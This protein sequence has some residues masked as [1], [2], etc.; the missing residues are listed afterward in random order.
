[1]NSRCSWGALCPPSR[2]WA[3]PGGAGSF[4]PSGVF[5]LFLAQ[6]L[7]AEKSCGAALLG[8]IA[9][10]AASQDDLVS[11]DKLPSPVT[12]GYCQ[13]R[14]RLPLEKVAA[15]QKL[16]LERIRS[17][18]PAEPTWCGR[19]VRVVDGSSVSM[20]DTPS[21]QERYPQP[22]GQAKG[23]G[24]PVIRIVA[25]FSLGTG[26]LLELAKDALATS[27][28]AL[29]RSLWPHLNPG[30][31]LLADCG[32]CS[33]ADFYLLSQRGVDC[34]MRNHQRRSKGVVELERLGNNDR[35]VD[36]IKT[37]VR[38]KALTKK[39]WKT[40]PKTLRVR[41]ITV[42]VD[43]PGFRSRRIVVVT[44]LLDPKQ[45]PT[46]AFAELYRARWQA[47]LYL[48]NIKTALGMDILRCKEPDMVQKELA[49]HVIAYNLIRAIMV[50][51]ANDSGRSIS[52]LSFTG[53]VNILRTWTPRLK[54]AAQ[55]HI[56]QLF[57]LMLDCLARNPL[58]NRPDRSEPRAR[59]RR[60]KNYQLLNKPRRNFKEIHH[61]NRHQ[62]P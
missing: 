40:I 12:G 18:L 2:S 36:W 10:Q 62:K 23:C 37:K 29:F 42:S 28:R 3:R 48:R 49:M 43:I 44:T 5:W 34:V 46:S 35:I 58:P 61:R 14:K 52:Q 6:V 45:F 11:A 38:P 24:F 31:V 9:A 30:D 27:E 21:N 57:K 55:I 54:N 41:E 1:M 19:I 13:A 7:S 33:Y 25:L 15:L 51:T 53:T 16:S 17:L 59:K 56:E 4:P 60:P 26:L 39:E 47:E 32:F 20:P 50:Q 22:T 8:Y